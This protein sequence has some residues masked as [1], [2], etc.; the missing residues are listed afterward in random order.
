VDRPCRYGGEEFAVVIPEVSL[1][2]AAEMA[3]RLRRLVEQTA[4][5]V[6]RGSGEPIDL[7]LTLSI[8]VASYPEHAR[9]VNA[10]IAA[11]D[12]ALYEAKASGRNRV[13]IAR[14]SAPQ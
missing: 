1:R 8:G 10:L 6:R 14:P 12:A 2:E 4:F 9:T 3:E 7:R 5:R 13:V 11:C